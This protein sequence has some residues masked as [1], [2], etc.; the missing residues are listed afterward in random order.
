MEHLTINL[1]HLEELEVRAKN[2]AIENH[3]GHMIDEL[4]CSDFEN[5]S[6]YYK[7]IDVLMENEHLIIKD[8]EKEDL[9][10]FKNGNQANDFSQTNCK[11]ET[12][13]TD[14]TIQG[15]TYSIVYEEDKDE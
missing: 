6:D 5:K 15:E 9:L 4:Y 10:F 2:K 7:F 13:K 11:K 8:I 3:R 1:Y 12:A 14:V